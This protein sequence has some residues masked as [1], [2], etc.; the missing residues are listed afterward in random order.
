M[1]EAMLTILKWCLLA[2]LYLFFFRVLQATWFGSG[3]SAK[4]KT[5]AQGL[6]SKV[7]KTKRRL[8]V[9]EPTALAGHSYQLDSELTMG[10]AAGCQIT[11]DDTY[12][13]QLHAR[14]RNSETGVIVE[15]LGSTNGTYLNRKRVMAPSVVS[16]GDKIQV[17]STVLELR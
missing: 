10:R 5:A 12:I 4:P 8:V 9:L 17:G 13:S 1:S 2:L 16:P 6:T 11:L 7:R 3:A 15:D 14:V